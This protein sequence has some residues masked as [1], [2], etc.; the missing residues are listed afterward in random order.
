M[1]AETSPLLKKCFRKYKED[2]RF[3]PLFVLLGLFYFGTSMGGGGY[4]D[5]FLYQEEIV[6]CG[7]CANI[8]GFAMNCCGG[9]LQNTGKYLKREEFSIELSARF[10][11][12][13]LI[14]SGG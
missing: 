11:P 14:Q 2:E 5:S 9:Q 10:L 3:L 4:I 12:I 6:D 1:T 8:E 7:R 13:V